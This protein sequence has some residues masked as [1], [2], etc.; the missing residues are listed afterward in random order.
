M[1]ILYNT[2]NFI[3]TKLMSLK[4]NVRFNKRY[5]YLQLTEDMVLNLILYK[6][7]II[8]LAL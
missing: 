8:P 2:Y 1:Y 7:T 5:V 6:H 3:L 4:Y